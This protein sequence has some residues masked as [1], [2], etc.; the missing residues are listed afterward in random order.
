MNKPSR[1]LLP[2]LL[3]LTALT[4]ATL[5]SCNT[6][7]CTD[8]QNSLPLAGIYSYTTGGSISI[9][10]IAIGGSGAPNDSLLASPGVAVSQ[11]YLPF[12]ASEPYTTFYITY[13]QEGLEGMQDQITFY[14]DSHPW[15]ASE[16]C[17]AMY[18]YRITRVAHTYV[19]LD[20]VGVSDS[21][22]T[23]IE[24]ET[25]QLFFRTYTPPESPEEPE[26]PENPEN[27]GDT[28]AHPGDKPGDRPAD[29]KN[30]TSNDNP[31]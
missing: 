22:I 2:F 5:P 31:S 14:Y 30:N 4:A 15:F 12:R 8:N 1:Y 20:S 25:I 6:T 19:L 7:G 23:N 11:V 24:R 10:G 16:E 29:D 9:S 26:T 13:H 17:G 21:L 27:P 3:A 18:H 28:P